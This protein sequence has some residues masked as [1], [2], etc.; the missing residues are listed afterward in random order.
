M[1]VTTTMAMATMTTVMVLVLLLMVM[2]D[3][4]ACLASCVRDR[5]RM[6]GSMAR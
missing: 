2:V 5:Y 1:A 3:G 4:L 6:A